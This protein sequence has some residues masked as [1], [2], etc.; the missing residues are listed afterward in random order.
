MLPVE[1]CLSPALFDFR[2]LK[3]GY[4][5]V[6]IDVLRATSSFAAALEAGVKCIVPASDLEQLKILQN[7]GMLAAAERDGK[8]VDFADF[9]NS[10]TVFLNSDLKDKMLAYSTTNGTKA[11]ALVLDSDNLL[12]ASFANLS[13]VISLLS[14]LQQP[15]LIVCSGWK[16]SVSLEDSV[17]AGAIVSA[18]SKSAGFEHY[19]DASIASLALWNEARENLQHYCSKGEHYN[20]LRN[21]ELYNDLDHCFTLDST[22]IIP[23]WNGEGFVKA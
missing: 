3:A 10:P 7:N 11:I 17:C 22:E 6:V 5:A 8:K 20:R 2:N 1:V 4:V 15:V 18:L 14:E 16:D 13:A 23:I 19:G 12:L 21:L 9:G